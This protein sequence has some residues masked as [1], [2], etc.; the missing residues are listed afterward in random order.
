[1]SVDVISQAAFATGRILHEGT[2]MP[3]DGT[4]EITAQE[5]PIFGALADDGTFVLSCQL[6][7]L[8]QNIVAQP[9]ALHL[10]VHAVSR[11]FLSGTADLSITA[12]IP[13]GADFDPDVGAPSALVD[14]GTLSLPADPVIIQGKVMQAENSDVP[15]AG[16]TIRLLRSSIPLASTTS[17]PDGRYRINAIK[18]LPNDELECSAP[19][20]TTKKSKLVPDFGHAIAEQYFQLST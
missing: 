20:Y 9:Y 17:D 1:M 18:A 15:I 8:F 16:A 5:G 12:N 13:A 2:G 14:L 11:Q 10:T 19:G 3:V 7:F 6:N 4:V